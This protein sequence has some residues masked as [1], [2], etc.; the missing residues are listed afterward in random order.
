M[1]SIRP[2]LGYRW[3][4]WF[5]IVGGFFMVGVGDY[6]ATPQNISVVS[7]ARSSVELAQSDTCWREP[8]PSIPGQWASYGQVVEAS[9]L[10]Q[11]IS[12]ATIELHSTSVSFEEA[13][14]KTIR[15]GAVATNLIK[16]VVSDTT[17]KFDFGKL[18]S[19]EYE[20]RAVMAGRESATAYIRKDIPAQWQG[21][22]LK[23][24]LS[25]QGKG[26]SRIYAAG[27]DDTDCGHE[28][29][30]RL[31]LG[32]MRV[33]HAN[34]A[35]L[36]GKRLLFYR[37]SKNKPR[38]PEFVLITGTNGIVSTSMAHGCYDILVARS[39]QIHL[40]FSRALASKSVTVRLPPSS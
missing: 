19:G 36:S 20:I 5:G 30:G 2:W 39:S 22:G 4:S 28:D 11:A 9:H 37:H 24:A 17:G 23:V 25:D 13:K 38:S 16:T 7:K 27:L 21:R 18:P 10:F 1:K 34:G 12:G 40:C 15:H 31:P 29:C 26:C 8:Y 33:I 14:N 6:T 3:I 32:K 35:P